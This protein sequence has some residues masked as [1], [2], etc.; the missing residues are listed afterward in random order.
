MATSAARTILIVKDEESVQLVL[1]RR[2]DW[3]SAYGKDEAL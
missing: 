2:L 3:A 1:S